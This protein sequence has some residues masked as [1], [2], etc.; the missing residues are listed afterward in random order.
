MKLSGMTKK[1]GGK[2]VQDSIRGDFTRDTLVKVLSGVVFWVAALTIFY[3]LLKPTGDADPGN[4][5]SS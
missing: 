4:G 2:V 1:F 3:I 5:I